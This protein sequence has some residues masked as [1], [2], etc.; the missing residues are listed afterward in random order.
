MILVIIYVGDQSD[1]G[2]LGDIGDG[3]SD[4]DDKECESVGEDD[5]DPQGK[6][7]EGDVDD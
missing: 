2:A 5:Y 6:G 7:N 4:G 3:D 1:D